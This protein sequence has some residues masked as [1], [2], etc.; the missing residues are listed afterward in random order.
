[1]AYQ[2]QKLRTAAESGFASEPGSRPLTEF[3]VSYPDTGQGFCWRFVFFAS[4]M[5]V[6]PH[7]NSCVLQQRSL[8]GHR[9]CRSL[10][11]VHPLELSSASLITL[12]AG[13]SNAQ[14]AA[15]RFLWP[16]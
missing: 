9:A 16:Q 14:N 15:T 11:L 1:L 7:V 12:S 8:L 3:A 2:E 6:D 13:A 5:F 10:S 4:T